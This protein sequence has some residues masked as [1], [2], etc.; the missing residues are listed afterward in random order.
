MTAWGDAEFQ[1]ALNDR[2]VMLRYTLIQFPESS[3][4]VTQYYLI[5]KPDEVKCCTIPVDVV[6]LVG[7]P[8]ERIATLRDQHILVWPDHHADVYNRTDTFV[9]RVGQLHFDAAVWRE[10]FGDTHNA[11][12]PGP[13]ATPL[14]PATPDDIFSD[15]RDLLQN[16]PDTLEKRDMHASLDQEKKHFDDFCDPGPLHAFEPEA[17]QYN[18]RTAYQSIGE[19]IE[20][21]EPHLHDK[22][23][24][25]NAAYIEQFCHRMCTE[26]LSLEDPTHEDPTQES[27]RASE[28]YYKILTSIQ[29]QLQTYYTGPP[30]CPTSLILAKQRRIAENL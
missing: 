28:N 11:Q 24:R 29:E 23:T 4:H 5:S 12:D 13:P 21:I 26:V 30:T 20:K 17:Y 3:Q 10:L 2:S 18:A 27:S 14:P 8:H 16:I 1:Q 9:S 19:F 25:D 7:K 22:A 6:R 15:L